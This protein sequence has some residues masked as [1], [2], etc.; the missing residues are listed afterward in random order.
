M[1]VVTKMALVCGHILRSGR[2]VGLVAH[3]SDDDWQFACGD[4]DHLED[5]SDAGTIC[6][7]HLLDRQPELAG[8]LDLDRGYLAE[9]PDNGWVRTPHDD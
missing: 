5:A 2:A 3:H 1:S 4:Y 7:Q 9:A 8:Q 6:M